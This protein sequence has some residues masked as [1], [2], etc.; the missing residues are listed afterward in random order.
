MSDFDADGRKRFYLN[1]K[2]F[3]FLLKQAKAGAV[4]K[5]DCVSRDEHGRRQYLL[6]A[7][8][9]CAVIVER[10]DA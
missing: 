1:T 2:D 8:G 5:R 3:E 4:G 10:I 9:K 7:D 6:E